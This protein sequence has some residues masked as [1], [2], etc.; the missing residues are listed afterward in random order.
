MPLT[1]FMARFSPSHAFH[2][3]HHS[4]PIPI[5]PEQFTPAPRSAGRHIAGDRDFVS[6]HLTVRPRPRHP[7]PG[8][9]EGARGFEDSK[10]A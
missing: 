10:V 9:V 4:Q 3:L 5:E 8:L 7:V 2:Y 1:V 6:G